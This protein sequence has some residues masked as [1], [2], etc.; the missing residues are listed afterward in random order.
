MPHLLAQPSFRTILALASFLVPV[1]PALAA[2]PSAGAIL[3]QS[4][5]SPVLPTVPGKGITVIPPAQQK[6]PANISVRV[7]KIVITGS[8]LIQTGKLEALLRPVIGKTVS[9]A[10]LDAAVARITEA[11]HAAGYPLAYAYLPPQHIENGVVHVAVIEPRYDQ[12]RITGKSRLRPFMMRRIVGVRPGQPVNQPLLDRGM[13]LLNQTP[14][15]QVKG[16][17]VPGAMP[18]TSTLELRPTDRPILSGL[19]TQSDY[20]NRDTGSY[21]TSTTLSANNPFGYGSALAVNGVV[22]DTGVFRVGGF[23][24]TS[25]NL[26]RGIRVGLY[27]SSASYKIGHPFA[28]LDELGRSSVLGADVNVPLLVAPSRVLNLRADLLNNW[29]ATS[30]RSQGTTTQTDI[31][32]ARLGLSGAIADHLGGVTSAAISVGYGRLEL[33]P[34]T[35]KAADS[36]G[37][38]AAGGFWVS[39]LHLQRQQALPLGFSLL[40]AFSGQLSS[41]NLDSSQKFY[42]GGPYGVLSYPVGAGGGDEGY[43]LTVKLSHRIPLSRLPGRLSAAVLAETGTVW[44]NHSPYGGAAGGQNQANENGAGVELDYTFAHWNLQAAFA[45]QIGANSAVLTSTRRNEGLFNLAYSF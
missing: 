43:L 14:G 36:N 19:V 17:L 1:S 30:T 7:V 35:V 12:V 26:W 9:L 29:L 28:A 16:V 42:L 8:R 25:P 37:P 45:T 41:K 31:P 33:A 38:K 40:M 6:L 34:G 4:A 44:I 27:G 39:Q 13:L 24:T 21:L 11:Y 22:S 20:G 5:P 3:H 10:R 32:M 2:A 18:G 15:L 23:S